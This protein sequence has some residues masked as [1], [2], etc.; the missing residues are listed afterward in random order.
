MGSAE[1]KNAELVGELDGFKAYIV[2][3]EY[4]DD[5]RKC[6]DF[7][8]TVVSTE[9]HLI[10][11]ISQEAF[12]EIQKDPNMICVEDGMRMVYCSKADGLKAMSRHDKPARKAFTKTVREKV[13]RCLEAELRTIKYW[14]DGDVY[15]IVVDNPMGEEVDAC[16]GFYGSEH[17]KECALEKMQ[18]LAEDAKEKDAATR[19]ALA[20]MPSM[21]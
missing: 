4:S 18:E 20:A 1:H 6:M 10:W 7:L 11:S 8:G 14:A 16:W 3:D 9:R 15:G 2:L 5:P 21:G 19:Q 17:A 12:E 13:V